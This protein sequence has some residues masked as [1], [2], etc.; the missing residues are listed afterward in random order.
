MKV[1]TSVTVTILQNR[2]LSGRPL[3]TVGQQSGWKSH[4]YGRNCR[5]RRATLHV[6]SRAAAHFKFR[7][8]QAGVPASS[9]SL[10]C[11]G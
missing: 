4:E 7:V 11:G 5:V 8:G 1:S 6:H 9:G 2:D 10:M 3:S